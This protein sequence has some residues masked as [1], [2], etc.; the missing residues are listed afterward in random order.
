[1]PCSPFTNDGKCFS[2]HYT[3]GTLNLD[4][5]YMPLLNTSKPEQNRI[6]NDYYWSQI[7]FYIIV[8][9]IE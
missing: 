6:R 8:S 5:I 1:M 2:L 9:L 4:L 7:W 3:Y